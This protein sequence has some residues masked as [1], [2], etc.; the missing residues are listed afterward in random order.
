MN[1][2]LLTKNKFKAE[3]IKKIINGFGIKL[4]IFENI[5]PLDLEQDNNEVFV[6]REET[7]LEKDG[8]KIKNPSFHHWEVVRELV[9][10]QD[11]GPW[12]VCEGGPYRRAEPSRKW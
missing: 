9:G 8:K 4:R 1:V 12:A 2:I 5:D 7:Y 6:L 3:E 11:P 10:W